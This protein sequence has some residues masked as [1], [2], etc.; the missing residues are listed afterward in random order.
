MEGG[1]V[2]HD[3]ATEGAGLKFI[4]PLLP[5]PATQVKERVVEMGRRTRKALSGLKDDL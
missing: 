2:E 1:G 3:K 4:M 5:C